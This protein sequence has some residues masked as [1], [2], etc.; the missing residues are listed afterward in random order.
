MP[1][2]PRDHRADY[3]DNAGDVAP[4]SSAASA[5][6]VAIIDGPSCVQLAR[7]LRPVTAAL[8]RAGRLDAIHSAL[9][10]I[11]QAAEA[12]RTL[13]RQ[14]FAAEATAGWVSVAEASALAGVTPQAIRARLQRGTLAGE[15]PAGVA[16]RRG[17]TF[18]NALA[19][20]PQRPT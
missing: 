4:V 15:R 6:P 9:N 7:Y 14:A 20:L 16:S 13:D 2:G 10:A 12:Q 3:H 19:Q 17:A 1:R 11:D 5:G 8:E 18:R